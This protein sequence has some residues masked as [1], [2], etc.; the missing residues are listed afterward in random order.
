MANSSS[1]EVAPGVLRTESSFYAYI[2]EGSKDALLSAGLVQASWLADGTVRNK[3]GNVVRTLDFTADGR[4]IRTTV[5]S[6]KRQMVLVYVYHT[7]AEFEAGAAS[8]DLAPRLERAEGMSG[9]GAL[10]QFATLQ[11]DASTTLH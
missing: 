2:L 5:T 4:H 11:R 7:E 9:P 3:R 1:I 10:P 8:G 6:A